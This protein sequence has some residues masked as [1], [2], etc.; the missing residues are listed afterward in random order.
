MYIVPCKERVQRV[1]I[2]KAPKY[3]RCVCYVWLPTAASE[4]KESAADPELPL[5]V[6]DD[7]AHAQGAVRILPRDTSK[8]V[9]EAVGALLKH[10]S[11]GSHLWTA[12]AAREA[13]Q[14]SIKVLI[15]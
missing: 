1:S 7:G 9:K 3:Q 11:H 10:D 4:G 8:A 5:S 13:R 14:G 2:Y 6:V 12:F 15:S